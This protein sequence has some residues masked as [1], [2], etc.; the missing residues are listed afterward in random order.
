MSELELPE[1]TQPGHWTELGIARLTGFLPQDRFDALV[2][3]A[4]EAAGR[5]GSRAE[6]S[7]CLGNVRWGPSMASGWERPVPVF[8]VFRRAIFD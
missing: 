7:V 4:H 5:D 2:A 6:E 8:R 1:R 3:E